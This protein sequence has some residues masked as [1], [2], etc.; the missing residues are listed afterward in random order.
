MPMREQTPQA[1]FGADSTNP[2]FQFCPLDVII[3][4]LVLTVLFGGDHVSLD[5][6]MVKEKGGLAKWL[7]KLKRFSN[8]DQLLN[9]KGY[10][11]HAI[12]CACVHISC[13]MHQTRVRPNWST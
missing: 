12:D 8:Y 10:L 6:D 4:V 11:L 13:G 9:E 5:V 1:G 3:K 2:V 7:I